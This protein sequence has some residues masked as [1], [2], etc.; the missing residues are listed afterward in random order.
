[1]IFHSRNSF[2]NKSQYF[3]L[4]ILLGFGLSSCKEK[5]LP[6]KSFGFFLNE[7]CMIINTAQDNT[8]EGSYLKVISGGNTNSISVNIPAQFYINQKNLKNWI[9][10]WGSNIPLYDAGCE[11]L[12]AIDSI[13]VSSNTIVLGKIL[14]GKDYPENNQRIVFWNVNPSAF[15]KE[16]K[17]A[18]INPAEWPDFKG[19][20]VGFSSIVFDS[21]NKKWTMLINEVDTDNVQVYSAISDNLV[22]WS[23]ANNGRPILASTDFKNVS[24]AGKNKTGTNLQSAIV[25]DVIR[26][27][28]KWYFFMDGYDKNGKRHIGLANSGESIYGPYAIL[29]EPIISPG[30]PGEWNDESCFDA[31]VVKFKKRFIMLFDGRNKSG[32][33]NVGMATSSDMVHWEQS[34]ANPVLAQHNGWRSSV[35]S[36][37][38]N[39]VESSGDSIFLMVSGV[40]K[41]KMGPWHH[42]ITRRMYMDKSGNVND[43]ELGLFLSTDGGK[44]FIPHA[45]NPVFI[46]DYSDINENDHMGGN[47][48]L[49]KTDTADFIFYQAKT[50]YPKLKYNIFFRIKRKDKK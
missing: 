27:N 29:S 42:Y 20:S 15:I 35:T 11:N 9:V 41:L 33:E 21:T 31:K 5:P 12:R 19:E 39:F 17:Q 50:N 32:E 2:L 16:R 24:W 45:N 13:N 47:F 28:N 23:P 30:N 46:N 8:I 10:G 14:R 43:A 22:N 25:S 18:I 6:S 34:A 4:F 36:A 44:T 40:K 48:K 26:F 49:I 1:M 7:K 3:L 37:E 38:P